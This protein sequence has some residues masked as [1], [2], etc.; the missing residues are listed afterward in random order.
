LTLGTANNSAVDVLLTGN[1][2]KTGGTI[3]RGTGSGA[4]TIRFA[5]GLQ[6][7][8]NDV[9]IKSAINFS[10]ESGSNLNLGTTFL[11]GLEPLL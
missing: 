9:D 11:T 4:G 2:Q 5:G 6:T 10:V 3:T 1:F 7:Y 8:A